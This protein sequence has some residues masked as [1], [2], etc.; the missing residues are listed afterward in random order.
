MV[1]TSN[2][3]RESPIFG[4]GLGLSK[5]TDNAAKLADPISPAAPMPAPVGHP[6]PAKSFCSDLWRTARIVAVPGLFLPK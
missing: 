6:G 5:D 3:A 2:G 1:M 4:P